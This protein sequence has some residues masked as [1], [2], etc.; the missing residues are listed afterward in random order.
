MKT[1]DASSLEPETMADIVSVSPG[2]AERGT[3]MSYAAAAATTV[4]AVVE[5]ILYSK[6]RL[7]ELARQTNAEKKYDGGQ[8]GCGFVFFYFLRGI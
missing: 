6:R 2:I 4:V 3:T 5:T 1:G 7:Y 8:Y